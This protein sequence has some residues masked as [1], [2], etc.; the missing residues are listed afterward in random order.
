MATALQDRQFADVAAQMVEWAQASAPEAEGAS[1]SR[2]EDCPWLA[3]PQPKLAGRLRQAYF[4]GYT[5]GYVESQAVERAGSAAQ[6]A[7]LERQLR[8]AYTLLR[9]WQDAGR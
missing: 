4:A 8:E 5:R 1:P 6:V 7:Q 3:E 9:A 2:R